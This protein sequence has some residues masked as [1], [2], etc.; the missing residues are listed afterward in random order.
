MSREIVRHHDAADLADAVAARLVTII[1]RTQA[2]H[3]SVSIV[4]T[5]GRIAGRVLY[6]LADPMAADTIDWSRVDLW[7]GDE[8]YLPTGD[9]ERND[10]LADTH[11]LSQINIPSSCVHRIPGPDTSATVEDAA[12]AFKV[13]RCSTSCC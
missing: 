3:G 6:A 2:D 7:W 1:A 5:G 12:M 9:P 4:L 10:Y 8:R 13:V 11:L